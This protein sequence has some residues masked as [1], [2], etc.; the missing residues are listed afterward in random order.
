LVSPLAVFVL[1]TGGGSTG[2][3]S[4][5]FSAGTAARMKS[6]SLPFSGTGWDYNI[7]ISI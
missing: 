3:T 1:T 2:F 6:L 5:F 4:A 7:L